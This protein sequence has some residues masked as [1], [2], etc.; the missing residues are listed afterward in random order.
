MS[1]MIDVLIAYVTLHSLAPR[2]GNLK[3]PLTLL[4]IASECTCHSQ[5]HT[6]FGFRLLASVRACKFGTG[7]PTPPTHSCHPEACPPCTACL[8]G[9]AVLSPQRSSSPAFVGSLGVHP[10]SPET[11]VCTLFCVFSLV[12][13]S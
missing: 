8:R 6:C 11:Q 2:Y 10:R 1:V 4:S 5:L 3:A 13:F 9:S 7:P 12:S